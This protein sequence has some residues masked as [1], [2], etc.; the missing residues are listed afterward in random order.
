LSL[1]SERSGNEAPV[2]LKMTALQWWT[3]R[4]PQWGAPL[5]ARTLMVGAAL[6]LVG[7]RFADRDLVPYILD[8]PHFQEAA[9]TH[10]RSGTWATI[11][12]L[13]GNLG[14]AYG[15]A[16][17]WFYTA[18][19][20]LVGPRPERSV[21]AVTLFLSFTEL[22]LAAALAR[23]LRGG[24]LLFATL[25]ALL[26][27]SPFLFFWSR[28]AWE[29]F[30]G[31][32]AIAVALL[33]SDRAIGVTRGALLGAFLGLGLTSH[34]MTVPFVL[35]ALAVVGWEAARRRSGAAGLFA[36]LGSLVLV[37]FPYLLALQTARR[38]PFPYG[39]SLGARLLSVPARLG[40][41]LLEPARI[42]TTDGVDYFFDAAWPDFRA[43]LGPV[44][45]LL[46]V[47]PALAIGLTL[48]LAVGLLRVARFGAPGARRVARVG[49]LAWVGLA[50]LLSTL[51]LV[52]HPH[53]Q[54]AAYWLVP[55]GVGA[56]MMALLPRYPLLA[57]GLVVCVWMVA[58]TE[59]AFDQAWMRWV[60]ERGGTAGIH[61]SVPMAG[62]RKLLQAACSTDRPQVALA[63]RTYIFPDSLLS[64]AQLEPAC[65]GKRVAIC[66]GNCPILDANWRVVSLRYAAPPGGQLA[67]V[68][69]RQ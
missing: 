59:A 42:L 7:L 30:S 60:R 39:P 9:R 51:G 20:H 36:L 29:V 54:L 63:N 57:R 47:G 2:Q 44:G 64:L 67:P 34:P 1:C 58:L 6:G 37:N 65:A 56:L 18:V 46:A 62:Q 26:A 41:Q 4:D 13:T 55:T 11:S 43:W 53:Y 69:P 3:V 24:S 10:A 38:A 31:Y 40:G 45:G 8:E 5:W 33:A 15:P 23:A 16:P 66:S 19:H 27:A 35:A 50:G 17:V 48:L 28:L 49:I 61:Y 32:I 25:T 22:L 12:P 14:V 21:L 68:L 52:V